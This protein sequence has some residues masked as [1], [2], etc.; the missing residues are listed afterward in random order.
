VRVWCVVCVC[1]QECVCG[2][3]LRVWCVCL[4]VCGV[5]VK[6]VAFAMN[7]TGLF[8]IK[9]ITIFLKYQFIK[10]KV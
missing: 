1:A 2:V 5:S 8:L 10:P 3:C 6:D 7:G 9:K 4:R